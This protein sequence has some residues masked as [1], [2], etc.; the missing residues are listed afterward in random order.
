MR[1]QDLYEIYAVH[2]AGRHDVDRFWKQFFAT[3][4]IFDMRPYSELLHVE[5]DTR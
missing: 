1:T 3:R 4:G 2:Q 5:S